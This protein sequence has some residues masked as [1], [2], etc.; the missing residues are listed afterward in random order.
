MMKPQKRLSR[1][2]F[3]TI[4]LFMLF[5]TAIVAGGAYWAHHPA[6]A[7]V[8]TQTDA[9]PGIP[10]APQNQDAAS[11][12]KIL[13]LSVAAT[14]LFFMI[15]GIFMWLL[16]RRKIKKTFL[17]QASVTATTRSKTSSRAKNELMDRN[18]LHMVSVLQKEGRLLD[19]LAEDLTQ[20]SDEQ[21]GA[22]VR[23]VHEGCS[24]GL[25]KYFQVEA[26]IDA[27]EGEAYSVEPGFDS[28]R[29][30]LSGNVTGEPPFEGVVRHRGWHAQNLKRPEFT[31]KRDA[32]ILAPAEIEIE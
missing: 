30:Q 31:G 26:M 16:I 28:A 27:A 14:G 8:M 1:F 9:R 3:W 25:K 32:Q 23:S 20:Y 21:I 17:D 6:Q 11:F 10:Q 18:F 12:Q 4:F 29:I 5:F 15:M 7:P 24:K 22:A 2:T 19:F 13:L